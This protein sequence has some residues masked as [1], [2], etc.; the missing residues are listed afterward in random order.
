MK[1]DH[2]GAMRMLLLTAAIGGMLSGAALVGCDWKAGPPRTADWEVPDVLTVPPGNEAERQAVV[3]LERARV[4]YAYRLEVL[5]TFFHERGNV[6]RWIWAGRELKNLREAQTFHWEG[7]PEITPPAGES[8]EGA[9]AQALVELVVAAREQWR[10]ALDELIAFYGSRDPAGYKAR[11]VRNVRERFDPVRTYLYFLDAEIP[12]PDLKPT[13]VIPAA[14]TLYDEAVHL[15]HMGSLIPGVP[16]YDKQREALAKFLDLVRTYPT[17]TKI[18]MSAY[19]IAEIYK[20]YFEEHVRSVHWYKRA[21]QWD[22]NITK[23]V[24]YYAALMYDLHLHN[25]AKAVELYRRSIA[26][27]PEDPGRN[28]A[29]RRRIEELTAPPS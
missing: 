29:A 28:D 9:D 1:R 10:E 21:W 3:A 18:A 24:R 6:D 26:E 27:D 23:P 15:H 8:V 12:G 13:E 2:T 17:S 25:P 20:E 5:E 14:N 22:P 7:I 11:R 19:Y 16:D 4:N